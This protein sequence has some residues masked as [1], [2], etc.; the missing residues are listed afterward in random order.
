MF[1]DMN[2]L[3]FFRITDNKR[4]I[5]FSRIQNNGFIDSKVIGSQADFPFNI[6]DPI[7]FKNYSKSTNQI[8]LNLSNIS[9]SYRQANYKESCYIWDID[10]TYQTHRQKLVSKSITT[11]PTLCSSDSTGADFFSNEY[12][13]FSVFFLQLIIA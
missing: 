7:A 4:I 5:K 9:T 13:E 2:K 10:V 8:K 6:E 1:N 11:T 3:A 12:Y